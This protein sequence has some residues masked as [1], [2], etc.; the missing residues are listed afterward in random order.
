MVF[1]IDYSIG[2]FYFTWQHS[3]NKIVSVFNTK[4]CFIKIIVFPKSQP[5]LS[6][7]S[8]VV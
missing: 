3:E 8:T 5:P 1:N 4:Y 6:M 7:H 2:K